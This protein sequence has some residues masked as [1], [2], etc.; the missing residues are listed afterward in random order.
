MEQLQIKTMMKILDVGAGTGRVTRELLQK[1]LK[2][3]ALER[4]PQMIAE[5]QRQKLTE[6]TDFQLITGD[7]Q[8]MTT[9][10]KYDC[11]I[12]SDNLLQE[13][14]WESDLQTVFTKATQLLKKGGSIWV[15]LLMPLTKTI[16]YQR[17]KLANLQTEYMMEV[18]LITNE[19]KATLRYTNQLEKFV[20]GYAT[21]KYRVTRELK[22]LSE[23][24]IIEA[25]PGNLKLERVLDVAKEI[26]FPDTTG[27]NF[28]WV[29]G[30]YPLPNSHPQIS[31]KVLILKEK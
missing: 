18:Q 29:D 7:Y 22:I 31:K 15:E 5:M 23:T 13:L 25:L 11:L 1:N 28:L 10:Q 19:E 16:N 4:S 27:N 3:T 24:D 12:F 6:N 26:H 14:F 20:A 2:V 30:G 8:Q 9:Q 21:E 17:S